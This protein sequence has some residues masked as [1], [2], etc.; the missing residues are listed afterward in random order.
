VIDVGFVS[1]TEK[2]EAMAGAVAFCH[3]SVNESLGIVLLE[4]WLAGTP[5]LVHAHGE[6]LR[7]QCE[8]SNGGLWFQIYPEFEEAVL[9]LINQPERRRALGAAGRAYVLSEYAWDAVEQRMLE[10]M[11]AAMATR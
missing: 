10:S 8:S 9:M 2:F 6:V 3:P 1:E 7:Y 5:G 11:D 4:A